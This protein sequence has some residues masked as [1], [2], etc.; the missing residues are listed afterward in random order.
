M[1]EMEDLM[2]KNFSFAF[3][4]MNIFIPP[5]TVP[6]HKHSTTI[7][8]CDILIK[9]GLC[10]AKLFKFRCKSTKETLQGWC[11]D[12]VLVNAGWI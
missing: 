4:Q 2:L 3:L 12:E 5:Y 7:V 8:S 11:E 6:I 9:I 1:T 10:L